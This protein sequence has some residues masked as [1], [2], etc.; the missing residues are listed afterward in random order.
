MANL[1]LTSP[2]FLTPAQL[3]IHDKLEHHRQ[4]LIYLR[5]ISPYKGE[6]VY[7]REA[8]NKLQVKINQGEN[9]LRFYINQVKYPKYKML[10]VYRY[11][12]GMSYTQIAE[13]CPNSPRTLA[14]RMQVAI[15]E[16]ARLVV[17]SKGRWLDLEEWEIDV[18]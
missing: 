9:L 15:K 3:L 17:E 12:K 5:S 14:N 10:L 18:S 6:Y 13:Y 1:T 8:Y 16:L 7:I 4:L 11:L 2:D